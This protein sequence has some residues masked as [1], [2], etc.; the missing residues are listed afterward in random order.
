M[1]VLVLLFLAV[2]WVAYANGANDNLK[3]VATL[4]GSGAAS[5]RKALVWATATTLLGSVAAIYVGEELI[6]VFSG[7]G[8]VPAETLREPGFLVAVGMAAAATVSM[9]S[10][11]DTV[12]V[13][14]PT[15]ASATRSCVRSVFLLPCGHGLDLPARSR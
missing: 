14:T 13:L 7:K 12:Q 4:I 3:G 15:S 6:Q 1:T 8:L 11:K 9:R 2:G 5:Y 10:A